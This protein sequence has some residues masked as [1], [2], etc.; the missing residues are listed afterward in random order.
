MTDLPPR[1]PP[2]TDGRRAADGRYSQTSMWLVFLVLA[3]VAVAVL[4]FTMNPRDSVVDTET[5]P[6]VTEPVPAEPVTDP[7]TTAPATTETAPDAAPDA[8]EPV[9]PAPEILEPTE[10]APETGGTTEP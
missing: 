3:A 7:V 8:A 2:R 9:E 10:P 1:P 6:A 5:D 4:A